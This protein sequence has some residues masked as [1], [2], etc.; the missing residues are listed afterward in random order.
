[1]QEWQFLIMTFV[2]WSSCLL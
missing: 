1:M 2:F